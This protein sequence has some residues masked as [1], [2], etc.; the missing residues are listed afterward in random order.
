MPGEP[1]D[2][3][4]SPI[5][6][7]VFGSGIREA[8]S[9]L[10]RQAFQAH[11]GLAGGRGVQ[12]REGSLGHIPLLRPRADRATV[13]VGEVNRGL[14]FHAES[15]LARK[16]K[17]G[18]VGCQ[19]HP[20]PPV[21]PR[22]FLPASSFEAWEELIQTR[23]PEPRRAP[24]FSKE[25]GPLDGEQFQQ[26]PCCCRLLKGSSKGPRSQPGSDRPLPNPCLAS[27][28]RGCPP[29]GAGGADIDP[30]DPR[31][32]G[33]S[34]WVLLAKLATMGASYRNT[35]FAPITKNSIPHRM[36]RL[37][38]WCSC[39]KMDLKGVPRSSVG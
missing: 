26:T 34:A 6:G 12:G 23:G 32:G 17:R 30:K 31:P 8:G 13:R 19:A 38:M 29:K 21:T 22:L 24:G 4:E 7:L 39:Y 20:S 16:V 15:H 11:A 27:S 35:K 10:G 9:G 37:E 3:R 25:G 5:S 33:W 18:S 1:P 28:P 2:L 14:L 36:G